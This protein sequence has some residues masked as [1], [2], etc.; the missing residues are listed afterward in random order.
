MLSDFRETVFS[1][2]KSPRSYAARAARRIRHIVTVLKKFILMTVLFIFGL[3]CVD[4]MEIRK[5]QREAKEV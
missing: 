1:L 4:M 3:L 5:Q 2:R